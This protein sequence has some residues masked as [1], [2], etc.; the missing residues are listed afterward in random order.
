MSTQFS[1]PENRD[2]LSAFATGTRSFLAD[3]FLDS[4]GRMLAAGTLTIRYPDGHVREYRGKQPGPSAY[5]DIHDSVVAR[6]TMTGGALGFAESYMAGDC[7]SPD[8]TA[9]LELGAIN[10]DAFAR[11][12]DGKLLMRI[13]HRFGH[14][15]RPN[16][17]RGSR[18]N[19]SAHYDL[20]NEFYE[21]WLDDSMTYSSA[22]FGENPENLAEAQR[23]K[24]RRMAEIAGLR[25]GHKVLEIGCGWGGFACFAAGE[26]GCDVTALTISD[27]QHDFAAARVQREGL[28]ERVKIVKRDYRDQQGRFDGIV[29]IEMFEA[30]GERY[31]PVFFDRVRENLSMGGRAALQII[32][33]ADE[34]WPVYRKSADFIQAHIFPGGML[35]CPSGLL[36]QFARAGLSVIDDAGFGLDYA[37][38]L[39]VWR[40]RFNEAWPRIAQ[41]G[42]DDRFRRMWNYYLAYCEAGFRIARIDVR[43]IA[44]GHAS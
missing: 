13:L 44:L 35:P 27:A 34:F 6:R 17:K 31:W 20:G 37:H 11:R 38:T 39:A 29:S 12:L 32:T 25:Q 24:Y 16:T 15:L 3:H 41:M 10:E 18:R 33:I 42:F 26:I 5:L 8:L 36:D 28:G 40:E 22:L 43:Q 30:V 4:L 14:L 19:I 7:D 9:V 2:N 1:T 23:S 21:T